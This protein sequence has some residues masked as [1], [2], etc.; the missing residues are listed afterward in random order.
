M[1]QRFY[2][3]NLSPFSKIIFKIDSQVFKC[4]SSFLPDA[5]ISPDRTLAK[6]IDCSKL[7]ISIWKIPGV[8]VTPNCNQ[9]G[10]KNQ[11]C[12]FIIK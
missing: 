7:S 11:L 6:S 8:E 12:V 10:W 2:N 9:V 4:S 3:F 1:K 5:S